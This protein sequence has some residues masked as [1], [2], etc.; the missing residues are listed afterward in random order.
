MR[1]ADEYPARTFPLNPSAENGQLSSR[2]YGVCWE[3]DSDRKVRG[4]WSERDEGGEEARKEEGEGEREREKERKWQ[5]GG[6]GG[7][8]RSDERVNDDDKE[9]RG[10]RV[11]K[12]GLV[13]MVC[14]GCRGRWN[15]STNKRYISLSPLLSLENLT[16]AKLNK[17][18]YTPF[19]LP[20]HRDTC[21]YLLY[22]Q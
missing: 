5:W 14:E 17:A 3:M 21:T 10:H 22:R 12:I 13:K 9:E 18:Q 16:T 7:G 15:C 19:L 8:G 20:P 2:V 6:K 4:I 11:I 1:C